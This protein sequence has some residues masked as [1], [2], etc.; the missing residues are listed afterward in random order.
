MWRTVPVLFGLLMFTAC[1]PASLGSSKPLSAGALSE[2]YGRSSANVRSKYDGKE[3]IVRGYTAT[4]ATLPK[5]GDDQ[6]SVFLEEKGRVPAL[7]LTCWFSKEQ[8]GE[9]SKIKVG[10]YVTVKGVFNGEAGVELKFC[11]LVSME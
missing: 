5:P 7:R 1:Q 3:L 4:A 6:G 10:Q 2:E 8:A 9:F 11:K